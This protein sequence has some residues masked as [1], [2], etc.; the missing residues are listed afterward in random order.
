MP[1]SNGATPRRVGSGRT[2]IESQASRLGSASARRQG[3]AKRRPETPLRPFTPYNAEK[4]ERGFYSDILG[5]GHTADDIGAAYRLGPSAELR[6]VRHAARVPGN[7]MAAIA[8]MKLQKNDPR[9]HRGG[10]EPEPDTDMP[11][12]AFQPKVQIAY[13]VPS[14]TVPRRVEMERQRRQHENTN[15]EDLLTAANLTLR[16]LLP[17]GD[18]RSHGKDVSNMAVLQSEPYLRLEH[19]DD[20]ELDPRTPQE[21]LSLGVDSEGIM[22]GVPG[23]TLVTQTAGGTGAD[24]EEAQMVCSWMPCVVTAFDEASER[25]TVFVAF[26]DGP[27]V[28]NGVKKSKRDAGATHVPRVH[29]LFAAE[30]P[31]RFVERIKRAYA[32]RKEAEAQLRYNLVVDCMPTDIV[33]GMPKDTLLDIFSASHQ[34]GC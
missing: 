2:V 14:G 12:Q 26:D 19:F 32:A 9:M 29:L 4:H 27:T 17:G 11:R 33:E 28:R 8:D 31:E 7:A 15:F 6:S 34:V 30:N 1:G 24:V 25:Y 21:W 13:V 22:K 18:L 16:D 23:Y 10:L 20:T 3:S 5:G